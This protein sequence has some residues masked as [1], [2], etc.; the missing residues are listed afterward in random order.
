MPAVRSRE[1]VGEEAEE[2]VVK[3]GGAVRRARWRAEV[4]GAQG[5]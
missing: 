3:E 5:F 2:A 1:D 4:V